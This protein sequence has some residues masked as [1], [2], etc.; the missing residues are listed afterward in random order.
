MSIYPMVVDLHLLGWLQVRFSQD[1]SITLL[2]PGD[3]TEGRVNFAIYDNRENIS[4]SLSLTLGK[5]MASFK[6]VVCVSLACVD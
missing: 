4:N 1:V 5:G 3:W 6:A 2:H